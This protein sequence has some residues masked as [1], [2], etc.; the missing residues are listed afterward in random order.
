MNHNHIPC[1]IVRSK[2][3][4]AV[5]SI[6]RTGD[7]LLRVPRWVTDR[8]AQRLI[9]NNQDKL[10]ALVKKWER[11]Q[12]EKPVYRDED[13]PQLKQLATEQ[14]P[15]RVKYWADQMKLIPTAVKITSAKARFGSCNSRGSICFSCF[16]MLYPDDAIDAVIVHELAHLKHMDHSADF[17]RLVEQYLPDYRKR[18]AILKGRTL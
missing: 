17:Y 3:R 18:E 8:D 16:L 9:D 11:A 2:R 13:I 14:L 15:D 10:N 1:K 4:T 5:F 6:T 12:A 7:V